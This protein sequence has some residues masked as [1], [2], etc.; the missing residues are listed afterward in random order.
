M[1]TKPPPQRRIDHVQQRRECDRHRT[2]LQPWRAWYWT[3]EWRRIAK[4]QL[5]DEPLCAMCLAEGTVTAAG[6]CDHVEPHRG[7]PVKFWHGRRQSLCAHHHSSVKQREERANS[8]VP[9][10]R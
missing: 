8:L 1:P 9:V 7:D 4:Q 10:V 2:R 5:D 3:A 6:V